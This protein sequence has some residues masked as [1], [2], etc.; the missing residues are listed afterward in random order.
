[1]FHADGQTDRHDEANSLFF[2]NFASAPKT[3]SCNRYKLY[4][5]LPFNEFEVQ[6]P[7]R[8][9]NGTHFNL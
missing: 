7:T 8:T 9:K 3:V 6:I 2:R 1:L 5:C 4:Q